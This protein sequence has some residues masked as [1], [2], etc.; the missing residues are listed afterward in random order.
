MADA[1]I[2]NGETRYRVQRNEQDLYTVQVDITDIARTLTNMQ[3]DQ[4]KFQTEIITKIATYGQLLR[5]GFTIL[6]TVLAGVAILLIRVM[7]RIP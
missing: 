3:L 2:P 6:G 7:M 1:A 5:W 4:M